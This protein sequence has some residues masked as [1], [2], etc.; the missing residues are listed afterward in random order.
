MK[1]RRGREEETEILTVATKRPSCLQQFQHD[2]SQTVLH[3]AIVACNDRAADALLTMKSI[4]M[5]TNANVYFHIFT[6]EVCVLNISD[7]T[8]NNQ[9]M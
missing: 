6:D 3:F 7:S 9:F 5:L 2:R 4:V 8:P 1:K